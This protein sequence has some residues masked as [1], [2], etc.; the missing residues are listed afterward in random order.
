MVTTSWSPSPAKRAREENDTDSDSD[1]DS[2]DSG[3]EGRE[4]DDD[5]AM[6]FQHMEHVTETQAI[7]R[8]MDEP[9][10]TAPEMA[11]PLSPENVALRA[12]IEIIT[13]NLLDQFTRTISVEISMLF[14]QNNTDFQTATNSLTKQIT[15]LGTRVTQMQQQL[16]SAAQG[17]ATTTK[18]S[19]DQSNTGPNPTKQR[20]RKGKG[21]TENKYNANSPPTNNGTSILTYADAAKAP[22]AQ[23]HPP[24]E[25]ATHATNVEGWENLKK[26]TQVRKPAMPKVIPTMYP[27]AECEVTCHFLAASPAEAA[28]HTERDY[29][30]LQV[31]ADAA[32]HRVNKVLFDNQDVTAPPFLCAQV[33][34]RGSIIFTTTNTQNN[35]VYED[36]TTIIAD[37]LTYYGKC[38]KVEIGKRFSQFLLH[39]VPTHLPL[40]NISDSIA[41]N[42]PQLIQCQTPRWLTPADRRKLKATS[43][44]VMTLSGSTKKADIGRHYLTICNRECQLDDYISYGRSTQCR[45]CQGYGHP[46]TLCKNP[47]CCAV[48]A[49]AHETK[50][51]PCTIPA[52]KRG[53]TCTHPPIC[54]A[55]CD[56]PHKASHPN[57][58]TRIKI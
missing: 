43:T 55:N 18:P 46:T 4:E 12:D 42:Y 50:D 16:L 24:T 22:T 3:D 1:S 15:T 51:H 57:C 7:E 2:D 23:P 48:C 41:T 39:G 45:N 49:E 17:P 10:R 38:E 13:S 19:G 58:P 8:D 31:T 40:P 20:K 52:Y 25:H 11:A 33:T 47:S 28:T 29:I 36:Y 35:I 37:A 6:D 56:A 14:A 9:T 53:P 32:L 54:C 44:I 21:A 26:Q 5:N 30:A 34:M 27:Q